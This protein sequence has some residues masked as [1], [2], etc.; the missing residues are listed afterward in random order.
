[1]SAQTPIVTTAQS[2]LTPHH[3]GL[4]AGIVMLLG[5][6]IGLGGTMAWWS[7]AVMPPGNCVNCSPVELDPNN[8]VLA[9][10]GVAIFITLF[11]AGVLLTLI[12][13][14]LQPP[15]AKTPP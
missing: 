6:L 14:M 12:T 10:A 7:A 3:L 8:S 4:Y 9:I 11:A 1:V 15:K 5:G 13:L 2:T